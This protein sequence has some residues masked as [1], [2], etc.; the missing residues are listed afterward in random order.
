M[1]QETQWQ[2]ICLLYKE[3][4]SFSTMNLIGFVYFRDINR[5]GDEFY[6]RFLKFHIKIGIANPVL[7]V[8]IRIV[9]YDSNEYPQHRV[10]KRTVGF[11]MPPHLLIWSSVGKIPFYAP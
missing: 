11:R 8:L 2:S 10:W 9:P 4:A 5:S 1:E 7:W 3:K 6:D